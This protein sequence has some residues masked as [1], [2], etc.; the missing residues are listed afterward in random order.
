MA[1]NILSVQGK[2]KEKITDNCVTCILASCLLLVMV[3]ISHSCVS[4][5][6]E[7]FPIF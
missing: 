4:I 1:R 7:S 5:V 3:Y 2:E 6:E